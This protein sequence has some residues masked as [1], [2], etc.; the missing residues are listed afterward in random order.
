MNN[1][2]LF[3][4]PNPTEN[5]N[6][7]PNHH[8]IQKIR[9][10]QVQN[11]AMQSKSP[12]KDIESASYP[13]Q[14][15]HFDQASPMRSQAMITV[16][17][18]ESPQMLQENVSITTTKS[19]SNSKSTSTSTSISTLKMSPMDFAQGVRREMKKQNPTNSYPEQQ[20]FPVSLEHGHKNTLYSRSIATQTE[21]ILC[22][23]GIQTDMDVDN[24]NDMDNDSPFVIM[25]DKPE[26]ITTS[27]GSQFLR[28]NNVEKHREYQVNDQK[29]PELEVEPE[30]QQEH[31]SQDAEPL[32]YSTSVS[33]GEL[34]DDVAMN[35]DETENENENETDNASIQTQNE[36]EN[37]NESENENEDETEQESVS[38]FVGNEDV[39]HQE[40]LSQN[41]DIR[42]REL[43]PVI[44]EQETNDKDTAE[45]KENVD[46]LVVE[47]K[48]KKNDIVFVLSDTD[49]QDIYEAIVCGLYNIHVTFI[50]VL[51]YSKQ[52]QNM[53]YDFE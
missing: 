26:I 35:V 5:V 2:K 29:E 20:S 24:M 42:Q 50:Y 44:E 4:A 3:N 51:F 52:P 12:S 30:M 43:S 49:D 6:G 22:E 48:F 16:P 9:S 25:K 17:I 13:Q 15:L 40:R 28:I 41:M 33:V 37:E 39:K 18:P 31:E 53:I 38:I 1:N 45:E 7:N 46:K 23:I 27:T 34:D 19:S 14:Q 10:Q 21:Y 8:E 11:G 36:N 32:N 47:Y